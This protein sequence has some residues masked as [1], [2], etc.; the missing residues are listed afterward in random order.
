M[1]ARARV[2]RV[3]SSPSRSYAPRRIQFRFRCGQPAGNATLF[4]RRK[5][6]P[7]FGVDR[8]RCVG[9]M[10]S[11]DNREP[12]RRGARSRSN[13]FRNTPP[14]DNDN[15]KQQQYPN[16]LPPISLSL[17]ASGQRPQVCVQIWG[18]G[19]RQSAANLVCRFPA[20][21]KLRPLSWMR[22]RGKGCPPV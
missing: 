13:N 3:C 16:G 22:C 20:A 9:W 21:A 11:L 1:S 19:R 17:I 10:G 7:E 6:T 14:L 8:T 15:L 12:L 18:L 4:E 5:S 2:M